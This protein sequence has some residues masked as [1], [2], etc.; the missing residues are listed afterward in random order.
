LGIGLDLQHN[1]RLSASVLQLP[2]TTSLQEALAVIRAH[3]VRARYENFIDALQ[4][5]VK[6]LQD[7]LAVIWSMHDTVLAF[8]A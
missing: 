2:E 4:P 6:I 5:P 3:G 7:I 8:T 1:G